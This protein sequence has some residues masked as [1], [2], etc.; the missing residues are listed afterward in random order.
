MTAAVRGRKRA[1][2]HF[3]QVELLVLRATPCCVALFAT[4]VASLV[5]ASAFTGECHDVEPLLDVVA[6][7][8]SEAPRV[9]LLREAPLGPGLGVSATLHL[10]KLPRQS[11]LAWPSAWI[12]RGPYQSVMLEEELATTLVLDSGRL[13]RRLRSLV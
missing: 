4:D 12:S 5:E 1:P 13:V 11:L 6:L 8:T 10:H 9:I 3:E 2:E 7:D